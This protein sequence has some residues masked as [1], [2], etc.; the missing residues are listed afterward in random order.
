M[1]RLSVCL[2]LSSIPTVIPSYG[3]TVLWMGF[4]NIHST[5]IVCNA[6]LHICIDNSKFHFEQR[7]VSRQH[8]HHHHDVCIVSLARGFVLYNQTINRMILFISIVHMRSTF[9]HGQRAVFARLFVRTYIH[10]FLCWMCAFIASLAN[11]ADASLIR[12]MRSTL[13]VDCTNITCDKRHIHD[14]M[15]V[16]RTCVCVLWCFWERNGAR[17]CMAWKSVKI[18][19][20]M[21][22]HMCVELWSCGH[23]RPYYT[24]ADMFLQLCVLCV[25]WV[26]DVHVWVCCLD[27]ICRICVRKATNRMTSEANIFFHTHKTTYE[28]NGCYIG[29]WQ[30]HQIE[31]VTRVGWYC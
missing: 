9:G 15:L 31:Y 13:F 29:W 1:S 30:R 27:Y 6:Y 24:D 4:L 3:C 16:H 10:Y 5:F 18:E 11:I 22:R 21:H 26:S 17:Q 28:N 12:M 14:V 23:R 2:C 19:P 8:H 7:L 20:N 25:R